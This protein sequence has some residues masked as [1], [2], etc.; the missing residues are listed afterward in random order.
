[1]AEGKQAL[2]KRYPPFGVFRPI[3]RLKLTLSIIEA[4]TVDG[5]AGWDSSKALN[6]KKILVRQPRCQ[7]RT[8]S[9]IF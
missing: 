2:Y 5:G 7:R 6:S 8:L 9:T 4:R 1:M 3:D